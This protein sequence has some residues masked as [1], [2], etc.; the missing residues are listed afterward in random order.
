MNSKYARALAGMGVVA[1]VAFPAVSAAKGPHGH[2]QSHGNKGHHNAT[3]N[4]NAGEHGGGH[5]QKGRHTRSLIVAGVVSAVGTD[6]TVQVDVKHANHHGS[7]LVG[8]TVTFD[9]SSA[10][11]RVRDV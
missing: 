8:Q 11:V 2:G 7:G 4:E 6:G 1:A 3:T 5:E 9:V 10:R